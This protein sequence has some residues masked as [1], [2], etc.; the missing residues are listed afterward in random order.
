MIR[1]G[2]SR[3]PE[4]FILLGA[5][6]DHLGRGETGAMNRKGEEDLIH[7][8][9]DDNASGVA[10][11][12]EIAGALARERAANT[13]GFSRNIIFSAWAGEEIGLIG[14]AW[15]AEHPSV[16][17]TN[18][19]AYLNFDMVGRLQDNKLTLQGTGSSPIWPKLIEKRNVAT[20]FTLTLQE[21]PYL[22]TDTTSIYP[23]GIPVLAFFTGS[24]DDYQRPTDKAD[25]LNY[26]GAERIAKFAKSL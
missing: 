2:D 6:Y 26:E 8:G 19:D 24:H 17:L 15:F 11:I 3:G 1:A 9:A 14:S 16:S 13:A 23:K 10:A 25:T 4:E 7:P 20:G 21:D 5:H 18:I 12:L 22:P